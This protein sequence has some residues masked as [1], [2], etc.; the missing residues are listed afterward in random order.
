MT[1]QIK[2]VNGLG[3]FIDSSVDS[4]HYAIVLVTEPWLLCWLLNV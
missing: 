2:G 4:F 1:Y 3:I